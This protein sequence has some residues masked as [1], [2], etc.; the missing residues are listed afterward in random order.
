MAR[1]TR[2]D[3]D[4]TF[5]KAFSLVA[6]GIVF[7]L[8][9]ILG[10]GGDGA[11][12]LVPPDTPGV[13]EPPIS[14]DATDTRSIFDKFK[15]QE[16]HRE[17]QKSYLGLVKQ[18]YQQDNKRIDVK[19]QRGMFFEYSKAR[20]NYQAAIQKIT[21]FEKDQRLRCYS[22]MRSLI[23]GV[24]YYD[25]KAKKKMSRYDPEKL[26]K[27][28]IFPTPP[29]CPASGT[30]SIISRDGRRFFHCSIH[31]TLRQK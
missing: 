27:E 2:K 3:R 19:E 23:L 13:S 4:L 31:G 21:D 25:K 8:S 10:C 14:L 22:A 28:G 11:E 12:P 29:T 18:I 24:I 1:E 26:L 7:V 17:Y 30:F 16:V 20:K 9:E 15:F 5:F 6:L